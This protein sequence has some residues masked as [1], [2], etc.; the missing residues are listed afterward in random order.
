MDNNEM[1]KK[2][3]Q[4]HRNPELRENLRPEIKYSWERSYDMGVDPYLRENVYICTENELAYARDVSHYLLNIS[5]PVMKDLYGFVAGT[6]FVVAL[7]DSDL[8]LLKVIGDEESSAWAKSARFVEGSMWSESL[9]GTN[10]GALCQDL[11]KPISVYGYEH[12]CLFSQVAASSSAPIIDNGS[13][14]G[15]LSMAAPFNKVSNHTLGMVVAAAKH[16]MSTMA[17]VRVNQYHKTVME[18]MSEGVLALD[19]NGN[20]TFMNDCCA[21]ML[22][23]SNQSLVDRNI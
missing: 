20:I 19:A 2:W 14:C 10:A 5:E 1:R 22:Q 13:I 9:V 16:I 6:G 18:S 17:L 21:Q 7:V 23:I 3:I 15:C 4:M 11:A 8:R 12:F